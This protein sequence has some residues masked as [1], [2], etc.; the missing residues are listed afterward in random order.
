MKKKAKKTPQTPSKCKHQTHGCG[1][2]EVELKFEIWT[3]H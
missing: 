1:G 2:K 3:F